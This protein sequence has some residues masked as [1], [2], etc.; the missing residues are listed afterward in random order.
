MWSLFL[1][2]TIE[3]KAG[4]IYVGVGAVSLLIGFL[5][6]WKLRGARLVYLKRQREYYSEKAQELQHQLNN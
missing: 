4:T 1:M 3:M 2:P 5:L 6:G